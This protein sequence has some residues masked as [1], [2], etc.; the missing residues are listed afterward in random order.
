[1]RLY[2][3]KFTRSV[4][5]FVPSLRETKVAAQIAMIELLRR[6][7][8]PDVAAVGGL[9]EEEPLI[10]D[11]GASRGLSIASL[12]ILKPKA[13]IIAFE[14]LT[15]LAMK[16]ESKYRNHEN[17][18]IYPYALSVKEYN[19]HIYIPIYRGCIMDTLAA[20]RREDAED[21]INQDRVFWFNKDKLILKHQN[22]HAVRLDDMHCEPNII[23]VYA[24]SHEPE[25]IAGGQQTITKSQPAIIVPARIPEIDAR[26]RDLGYRRYAFRD[27]HFYAEGEGDYYSW[28]LKP[29]HR[30][31]F[32]YPLV[33]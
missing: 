4:S 30:E 15:D 29:E 8:G 13:K 31:Q 26:L 32:I 33:T 19:T 5:M 16:L 14:P 22:V 18:R 17:V 11:V 12:L 25:V 28:Y 24:Q 21:W 27:K 6:P 9:I 2:A 7:W 1:M 20:L 23:K 3:K 10:V